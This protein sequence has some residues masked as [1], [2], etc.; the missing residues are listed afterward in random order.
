VRNVIRSIN[1]MEN[2]H[3]MH[4]LFDRAAEIS[5]IQEPFVTRSTYWW[6]DKNHEEAEEW[7]QEDPEL[8]MHKFLDEGADQIISWVQTMR[9]AGIDWSTALQAVLFKM[10]IVQER[11]TRTAEIVMTEGLDYDVAYQTRIKGK[12]PAVDSYSPSISSPEND[13]FQ[14]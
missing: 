6:L 13:H 14:V 12:M 7:R 9:S 5:A 8:D 1:A 10:D 4:H 2:D 3:D 11:L